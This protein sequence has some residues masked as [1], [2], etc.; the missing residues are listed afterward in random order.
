VPTS[1]V[2]LMPVLTSSPI[3]APSFRLTEPVFLPSTTLF[4][5]YRFANS[6]WSWA[7]Y[8]GHG[9]RRKLDTV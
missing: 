1:I 2:A 8:D 7:C 6:V 9:N 4:L 3:I 5:A